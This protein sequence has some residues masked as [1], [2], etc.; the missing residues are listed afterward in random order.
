MLQTQLCQGAWIAALG[1]P[2]LH[3]QSSWCKARAGVGACGVW[4]LVICR[5]DAGLRSRAYPYLLVPAGI[6]V[7]GVSCLYHVRAA[8]VPPASHADAA[9]FGS[10]RE[11]SALVARS[12][13][14]QSAVNNVVCATEAL[15]G[16]SVHQPPAFMRQKL[17]GTVV[18]SAW[19]VCIVWS[20]TV[21]RQR[22]CI[23]LGPA[24]SP[25]LRSKPNNAPQGCLDSA[26]SP[27]DNCKATRIDKESQPTYSRIIAWFRELKDGL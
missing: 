10:M 15:H 13:R 12:W 2:V 4:G 14:L 27:A 8:F 25:K 9:V 7:E 21:I 20:A 23:I 24:D 11:H 17:G 19:P 22:L 16:H 6:E 1:G 26:D 18:V 3:V 5:F